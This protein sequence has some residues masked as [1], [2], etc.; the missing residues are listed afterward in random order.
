MSGVG[1]PGLLVDAV[2]ACLM[3]ADATIRRGLESQPGPY[4][5]AD[6]MSSRCVDRR[7]QRPRPPAAPRAWET[8]KTKTHPYTFISCQITAGGSPQAL[9]RRSDRKQE[10]LSSTHSSS[11]SRLL[12]SQLLLWA[13]VRPLLLLPLL[14]VFKLVRNTK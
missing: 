5:G 13:D 11:S 6:G 14:V 8:Q 7:L 4:R 12:F 9:Y 2:L 3:R 10:T 1:V